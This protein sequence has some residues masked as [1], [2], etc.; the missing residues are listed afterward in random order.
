MN[1]YINV[2]KDFY[3]RPAGRFRKDGNYSGQAFREDILVPNLQKLSNGEKITLDFS[4]VSMAGS[5]FLEESFGGLIRL[6]GFNK[7][8][9]LSQLDLISPRAVIKEKIID[10]IGKAKVK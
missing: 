8:S 10:Y 4:G 7:N 6:E 2:A 5:S 1:I 9:I 3:P